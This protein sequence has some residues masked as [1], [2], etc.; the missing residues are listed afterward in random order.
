[1]DDFCPIFHEHSRARPLSRGAQTPSDVIIDE[2]SQGI[3]VRT[4]GGG[5]QGY[6]EQ[7]QREQSVEQ[8]A[9]RTANSEQSPPPP[10]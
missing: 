1:M 8:K 6:H 4:G 7:E 10:A 3:W 5:K 9:Q 2:E